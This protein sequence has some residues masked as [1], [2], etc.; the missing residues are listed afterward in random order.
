MLKIIGFIVML[1]S[2]MVFLLGGPFG[3]SRSGLILAAIGGLVYFLGDRQAKAAADKA[4]RHPC[5]HC[6]EQIMKA[7][8]VCPF[9]HREITIGDS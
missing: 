7:A 2:I 1:P 3:A 8:K 9:C 6:A 4:A 5:P